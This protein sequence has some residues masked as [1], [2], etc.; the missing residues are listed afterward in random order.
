[1]PNVEH[2]IRVSVKGF[3]FNSKRELLVIKGLWTE[4]NPQKTEYFAAPGGGV[5]DGE[6]LVTALIR[7]VLEETGFEVSVDDVVYI[8]EYIN[9]WNKRQLEIFFVGKTLSN[10]PKSINVDHEWKFISESKLRTIEF[11]PKDINPFSLRKM[12]KYDSK[13]LV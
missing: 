2:L 6:N 12:I 8:Q 1:M 4:K 5:N 7:E 11:W 10:K 13:L 9:H 3:F